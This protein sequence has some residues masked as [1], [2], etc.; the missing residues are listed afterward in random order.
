MSD[1]NDC[2]V[3]A[4][5]KESSSEERASVTDAWLTIRGMRCPNCAIRVR[6]SLLRLKGMVTVEVDHLS[7]FAFVRFNPTMVSHDQLTL[8]VAAAGGD[9]QH[10]YVARLLS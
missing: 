3:E 7:G 1:M 4:I 2:H 6:N 8:A 5:N 10:E 9:G